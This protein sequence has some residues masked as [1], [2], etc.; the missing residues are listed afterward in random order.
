MILCYAFPGS[1]AKIAGRVRRSKFDFKQINFEIDRVIVSNSLESGA[2]K[3]LMLERQ[4][5]SDPIPQDN[6]L[7][8]FDDVEIL[9]DPNQGN[10]TAPLNAESGEILTDENGIPLEL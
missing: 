1:G 4:S 5:L 3:Y 6:L 9:F 7:F 2:D 10:D 8:G